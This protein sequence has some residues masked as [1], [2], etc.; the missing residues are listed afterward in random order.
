VVDERAL[1]VDLEDRQ[2][3][4]VARLE[5]GVAGD[6]D[7]AELERPLGSHL[8]DDRARPVAE[9]AA[10]RVVEDDLRRYG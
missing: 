10:L 9:M 5:P 7:L 6:V 3:L 1:A 8:L 4:A 2:P